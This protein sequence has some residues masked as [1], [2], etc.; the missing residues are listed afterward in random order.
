M[1][2]AAMESTATTSVEQ[3]DSWCRYASE[4]QHL[5]FKE[6]RAQFEMSRLCEYCVALA[7]EGGGHLLLGITDKRPRAV[8]GTQA[9]RDIV[10]AAQRL[11]EALGFRVD[12]EEVA[13][14]NGRVVVFR[15]PSRPFGTVYHLD[16][17]YLMRSGQSLVPMSE[18]RL[19]AIF[20]EGRK[21]WLL[22]CEWRGLSVANVIEQLDTPRY[23]QLLK[24]PQPE[25][26]LAV[27]DR[28]VDAGLL[29]ADASTY[30]VTN[31]ARITLAHDIDG[32]QPLRR[33]APRVILYDG[34]GKFSTI[35]DETM[36]G[37]Y[38]AR[39]DDLIKLIELQTPAREV[40]GR[41]YRVDVRD[42]PM[43][44]IREL[45]ANALIHQDFEVSGATVMIEIYAGRI[46]ISSPGQPSVQPERF[47]DGYGCRNEPLAGLMRRFSLSEGKGSGFDKVVRAVEEYHLP[48]PEIRFD[49]IRTT[50]IL[51]G[52]RAFADMMGSDRIR[53]CYQHC[54]IRYLSGHPMTNQ[55]LRER[56]RL[57]DGQS[58][59]TKTSQVIAAALAAGRIKL[60]P[61]VEHSRRYARYLPHWA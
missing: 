22:E 39:F 2:V 55:S 21:H 61:V 59:Q 7:N 43:V 13:H 10:V 11:H 1:S 23:F 14:P 58:S 16:G 19:R 9:F 46:E 8:V 28:L 33:K 60:D 56:F 44:A 49:S 51:Y 6:A 4:S 18:D 36:S 34:T 20:A 24:L 31:L 37:G 29:V 42:Y 38:A 5:E 57:G 47:I 54:C 45:V 30:A 27:V 35:R 32:I 12:V 17:R 3:I 48:A 25:T 50:C 40:I 52:P 26:S 41:V 53:A 15:I